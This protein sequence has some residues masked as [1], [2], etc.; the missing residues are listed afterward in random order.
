M[1]KCP[2][3]QASNP[4]T[5]HLIREYEDMMHAR[6]GIFG[7]NAAEAQ[8]AVGE[9]LLSRGVTHIPNIFG[10]IPVRCS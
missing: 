2:V 9:M 4:D 3:C 6:F 1:E 7:R 8:N 5:N 10:D